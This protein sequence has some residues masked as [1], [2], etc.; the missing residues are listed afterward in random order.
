MPGWMMPVFRVL[1]SSLCAHGLRGGS[2]GK[3]PLGDHQRFL[4]LRWG[5][6]GEERVL[7]GEKQV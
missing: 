5:V 4:T 7:T 1:Q 2:V 6:D 3:E